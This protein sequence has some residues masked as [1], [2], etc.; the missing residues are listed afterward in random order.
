[1]W[2][3]AGSATDVLLCTLRSE[4]HAIILQNADSRA[5]VT[6]STVHAAKGGGGRLEDGGSAMC[7]DS[8]TVSSEREVCVH[9]LRRDDCQGYKVHFRRSKATERCCERGEVSSANAAVCAN[10]GG[11]AG[12][13]AWGST[14]R[15]VDSVFVAGPQR[16]CEGSARRRAR[17]KAVCRW[18]FK[19]PSR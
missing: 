11:M 4:Q 9:G 6:H 2:V 3:Q 12:V 13:L 16:G 15:V 19:P 1:M 17:Q 14:V 8:C 5:H 7:F 18:P 10:E